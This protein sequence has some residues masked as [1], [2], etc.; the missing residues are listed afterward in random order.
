M[1]NDRVS[2]WL[3]NLGL[4][5]YRELFQRNAITWDVLSELNQGD[6]ESLGVVLGH[7]KILLR[8][9]AQLSPRADVP[10]SGTFP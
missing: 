3:E 2:A 8:A 1:T 10:A 7:R 6:L 4:G 5:T 9:I